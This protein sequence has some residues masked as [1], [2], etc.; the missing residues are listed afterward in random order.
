MR[1][2]IQD[3]KNQMEFVAGYTNVR[4]GLVLGAYTLL[5][6]SAVGIHGIQK[7]AGGWLGIESLRS[8]VS[9]LF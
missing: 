8:C 9:G 5:F 4:K 3:S 1:F 2:R 7:R 6:A